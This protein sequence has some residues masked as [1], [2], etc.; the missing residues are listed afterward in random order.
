MQ[1]KNPN[2]INVDFHFQFPLHYMLGNAMWGCIK[3]NDCLDT[4]HIARANR[5]D[6]LAACL[7]YPSKAWSA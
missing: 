4:L 6:L 1:V 2:R 5:V 7:A 3:E